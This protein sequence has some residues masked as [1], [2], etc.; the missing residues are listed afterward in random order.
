MFQRWRFSL[1]LYPKLQA[2]RNVVHR[3]EPICWWKAAKALPYLKQSCVSVV[4]LLCGSNVLLV[5]TQCNLPR[6]ERICNLCNCN[7]VEDNLHFIFH[8]PRW[9]AIRAG[10]EASIRLAISQESYE[11]WCELPT[12]IKLYKALG[13]DYPFPLM[14]LQALRYICCVNIHRMYRARRT[15]VS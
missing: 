3:W 2:F 7:E 13:L 6:Y 12:N 14:D 10:M 11:Y 1:V 5:N 15:T 8:C 9:G 4:K